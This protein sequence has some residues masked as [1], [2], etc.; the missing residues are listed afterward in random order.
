MK[1]HLALFAAMLASNCWSLV[2]R[3]PRPAVLPKPPAPVPADLISLCMAPSLLLRASPTALTTC[4]KLPT[5]LPDPMVTE[6]LAEAGEA[7]GSG[8]DG[9]CGLSPPE[10]PSPSAVCNLSKRQ[11]SPWSAATHTFRNLLNSP[12]KAKEQRTGQCGAK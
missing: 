10:G 11:E 7:R 5:A 4:G 1:A 12:C 2:V 9:T 3:L 8:R 6:L